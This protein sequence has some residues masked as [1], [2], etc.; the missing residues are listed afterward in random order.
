MKKE[1]FDTVKKEFIYVL[2]LFFIAL[3]IF[4]ITFFK[5]SIL[6]LLR[7]VLSLFWLFVIPGYFIMLYWHEKIEFIER[8]FIGILLSAAIIG[9][10]SYYIALLGL[11][12]KYHAVLIPSV[13][14][15][16]GI[17]SNLIKK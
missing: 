10:S 17:V 1:I 9:M 6:V 14:I 11:N 2:F 3:I 4:K 15:L 8:F 13:L 5:E 16:I 12:I 7:N